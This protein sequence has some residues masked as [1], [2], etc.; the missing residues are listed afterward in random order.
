MTALSPDHAFE[1]ERLTTIAVDAAQSGQWDVVIQCYR[2]RGTLLE[3]MRPALEQ[4]EELL[5]LDRQVFD[6]VQATQALLTSLL[7]EAAATKRRLQRLRRRLGEPA[8]APESM[9]IEA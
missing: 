4:G 7:E 2:N 5:R 6:H 3:V 1:I 9:S 8:L